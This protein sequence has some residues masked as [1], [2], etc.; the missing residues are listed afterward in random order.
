[1]DEIHE[2]DQHRDQTL[3]TIVGTACSGGNQ[4]Q[5]NGEN[6]SHGNQIDQQSNSDKAVGVEN[7]FNVNSVKKLQSDDKRNQGPFV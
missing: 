5:H 3:G 7:S 6:R 1:M 4:K 2:E